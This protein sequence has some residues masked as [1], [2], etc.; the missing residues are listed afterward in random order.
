MTSQIV[1]RVSAVSTWRL[2]AI[3]AFSPPT[4]PSNPQV[5]FFA[6]GNSENTGL[7]SNEDSLPEPATAIRR[8]TTFLIGST[9]RL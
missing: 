3:G 4:Y 5:R 9:R 6:I 2:Q 7:G 1:I 8:L